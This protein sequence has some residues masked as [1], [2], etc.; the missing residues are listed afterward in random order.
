MSHVE[1]V[2]AVQ[3]VQVMSLKANSQVLC[4][5]YARSIYSR[6]TS[7]VVDG[8]IVVYLVDGVQIVECRPLLVVTTLRISVS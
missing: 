1:R 2:N 5:R 8:C 4:L 3:T 6:F 7:S